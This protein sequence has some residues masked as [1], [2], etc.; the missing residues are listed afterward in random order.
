M[1]HIAESFGYESNPAEDMRT[2]SLDAYGLAKIRDQ[3]KTNLI[4]TSKYNAINFI[5]YNLFQ[6]F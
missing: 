1:V 3:T 2:V 6:Q 5:P 4:H